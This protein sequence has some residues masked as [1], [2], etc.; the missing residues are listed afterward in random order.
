[1]L[2]VST[3]AGATAGVV[4]G[5]DDDD[6]EDRDA[7]EVPPRLDVLVGVVVVSSFSFGLL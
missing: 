1:M 6:D 3:F 4:A 2:S 7:L 5:T